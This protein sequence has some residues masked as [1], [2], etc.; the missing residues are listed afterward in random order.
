MAASTEAPLDYHPPLVLRDVLRE[1]LAGA[2]GGTAGIL[3][4]APFDTVKVRLQ[5]A[6]GSMWREF[7]AIVRTEGVRSLWRG[8]L[9]LSL[10]QAPVNALIFSAY[11]AAE[12]AL[13]EGRPRGPLGGAAPVDVQFLAGCFSGMV[14]AFML[15]PFELIKVQQQTYGPG[16]L[17][18]EAA[19]RRVVERYGARGL[20]RGVWATLLRDGPTFGVYFTSYNHV[21]SSTEAW[22]AA[23]GWSEGGGGGGGGGG[24]A[25]AALDVASRRWP[26]LL[27]GGVAGALSWAIALPADV[28]KSNIQ[29]AR[30]DAPAVDRRWLAVARRIHAEGGARAFFRGFLPCIVRSIPVNAITFLVMEETKTQLTRLQILV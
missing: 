3:S 13:M 30:M 7:G 18:L 15:S 14:Q 16:S 4:G 19:T 22:A 26:T 5:T 25:A 28:V 20:F 27:A 12:R 6:G 24:V 10:G 29:A 23:R 21:K 8:S 1:G 17:G 11:H 2:V 9:A